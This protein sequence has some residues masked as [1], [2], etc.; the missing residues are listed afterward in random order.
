[1]NVSASTLLP[2]GLHE[3]VELATENIWT[4]PADLVREHFGLDAPGEAPV[5]ASA[6]A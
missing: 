2:R 1:M 4:A 6:A 5:T 3:G